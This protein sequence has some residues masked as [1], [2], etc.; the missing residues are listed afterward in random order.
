MI[1]RK[2]ELER[3]SVTNGGMEPGPGSPM[4]ARAL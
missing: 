1:G 4:G 3:Y 2:P